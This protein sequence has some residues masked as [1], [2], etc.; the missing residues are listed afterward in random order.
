MPTTFSEAP[1][2]A[3]HIPFTRYVPFTAFLKSTPIRGKRF[4]T[5]RDLEKEANAIE[6]ALAAMCGT[7]DITDIAQP[8][9]FTPQFGNKSARFTIHGHACGRNTFTK[10]P[11]GERRVINAGEYKTGIGAANNSNRIPD[12]ELDT[13]VSSLKSTIE[14]AT[15]HSITR[16]E[17][18]DFIYG[19]GGVHFPI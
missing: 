4:E 9:K 7:S 1:G 8:I 6:D 5:Y 19:E 16:I 11:V 17:L 3:F 2:K 18:A 14:T 13:L 15:G 12:P 10:A